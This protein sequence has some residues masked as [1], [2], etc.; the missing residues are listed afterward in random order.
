M[1]LFTHKKNTINKMITTT[2]EQLYSKVIL[3]EYKTAIIYDRFL[4]NAPSELSYFERHDC[5]SPQDLV[6]RLTAFCNTYAGNF[7]M[8]IKKASG[9][10]KATSCLIRVSLL[11]NTKENPQQNT[12]VQQMQGF[13][14]PE[15]MKARIL[16]EMKSNFIQKQLEAENEMYKS[17][18]ANLNT[19]SGRM[20]LMLEN[21]IMAKMGQKAPMFQNQMQGTPEIKTDD[22]DI[23][24]E[25][26]TQA[27]IKIKDM[28]GARTLV[29]IAAKYNAD[30]I[31]IQ[32]IKNA[33]NG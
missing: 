9:G 14:D 4:N 12:Q 10:T 27:L 5:E 19:T 21:F 6:E 8:I 33:V 15:K 3:S 2:P 29:N 26:F 25:E 24:E 17:Q 30:D 7:S 16:E 20:G 32:T 1:I 31:M 11:G 13:E 28:L 23:S 22:D 18:L